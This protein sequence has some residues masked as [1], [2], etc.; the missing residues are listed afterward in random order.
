MALAYICED[1]GNTFE[2]GRARSGHKY[3]RDCVE[4]RRKDGR[5]PR[6]VVDFS[7]KEV[8]V[9]LAEMVRARADRHHRSL[10]G[11]LMTILEEAVQYAPTTV[12]DL[13]QAVSQS[14]LQTGPEATDMLRADRDGR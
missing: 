5:G 11:E 14:G 9:E 12:R 8:P 10:Q 4:V 7:I 13:R 1:C 2:S 6:Q 3:C